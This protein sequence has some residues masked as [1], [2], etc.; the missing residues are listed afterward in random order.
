MKL[1]I[2][3]NAPEFAASDSNGINRSLSSLIKDGPVVLVFLR[4]FS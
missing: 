1:N 3:S 4:G 2:G